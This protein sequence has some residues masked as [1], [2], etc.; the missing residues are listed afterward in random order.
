MQD[1]VISLCQYSN[2]SNPP[3]KH[4]VNLYIKFSVREREW[5]VDKLIYYNTT[6]NVR[7]Y[8]V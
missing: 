5:Y 2:N 8:E 1:F 7:I 3:T 4:T 6:F